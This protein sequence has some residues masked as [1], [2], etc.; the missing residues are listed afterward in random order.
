MPNREEISGSWN[1]MKGKL[2]Q[3]YGELT[4]DDLTYEE[5]KEDEMWGRL[6]K[7]LGKAKKEILS[8]FQ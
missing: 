1:E 6:E 7:K 5:G 8:I 4:D 2:K 3:N